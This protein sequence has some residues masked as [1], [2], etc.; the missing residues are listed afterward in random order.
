[1]K[2]IKKNINIEFLRIISSLFVIF[3]HIAMSYR[4]GPNNTFRFNIIFIESFTRVC[5]PVFLMITGYF[6]F[7]K[8]KD[9]KKIIKKIIFNIILPMVITQFFIFITEIFIKQNSFS[10]ISIKSFIY[11]ILTLDTTSNYFYLWYLPLLLQI[12]LLYPLLKLICKDNKN[13][14]NLRR[15]L[16]VAC[17]ITTPLSNFLKFIPKLSIFSQTISNIS[18]FSLWSVMYI[19]IGYELS[20]YFSKKNTFHFKKIFFIYF[21]FSIITYLST[22]YLEIKTL[23]TFKGIFFTYYSLPVV[24]SS[25]AF[26]Y[27]IMCLKIKNE[28]INKIVKYI[29]SNTFYIY[30]IHLPVILL[31]KYFN[32]SININSKFN[33]ILIILYTILVFIISL[34]IS[35]IIKKIIQF[36]SKITKKIK[37]R[38]FY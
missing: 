23:G 1:M 2:K 17:F 35:I 13:C 7:N 24:I 27:S 18:P 21:I 11:D 10:Y 22:R 4:I 19:L 12:Y 26:F 33:I 6:L 29:S 37:K 14:N 3:I 9:V 5:V 31:L 28:K 8:V 36:L 20:I 32:I 30:L 34:I 16:I 25:V 15:Y 38:K